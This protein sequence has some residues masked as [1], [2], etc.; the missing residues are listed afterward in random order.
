MATILGD[1]FVVVCGQN[2]DTVMNLV[3][4]GLS[5]SFGAYSL[6]ATNA[7]PIA[8]LYDMHIHLLP[9]NHGDNSG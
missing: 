7:L 9:L 3:N 5:F 4:P 1:M 2:V 6:D 8:S